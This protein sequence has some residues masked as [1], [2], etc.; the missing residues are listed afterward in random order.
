MGGVSF[1]GELADGY[2]ALLWSRLASRV[3]LV[4]ARVGARDSEELYASIGEIP[5]EEHVRAGG[6]IAVDANGVNEEL[7]NTQFIA[8]RV[9]D[10]IADRFMSRF[11]RRPSVD[12][13]EPDVRVNV[14]LRKDR[15]SVSVDLA[16]T[17]LHRRGYREPG[18]QVEAPMKE[19]LAAAMLAFADWPRIAE[20]GG[21]FVDPMC[22]SG[23]LVIEAA[24]MAG[25][26]APGLSRAAWG[27]ERWLG[28]DAGV[29]DGLLGE[30]R[31]RRDAGLAKLPVIEGY[32]LD[33]RAVDLARSCARR[34][35]LE[36]HVVVGRRALGAL[37]APETRSA[38]TGGVGANEGGDAG[39]AGAEAARG[40][41][42]TNP[43]YGERISAVGGLAALYAQFAE[44]LRA[45]FDGWHLA[46]ITPDS[47]LEAGLGMKA[48]RTAELYNG[49]I[50][51]R[52][53]VFVVGGEGSP[54]SAEGSALRSGSSLGALAAGTLSARTP[55][56]EAFENRLR[57]MVRH[58]EKWARRT[59]VSCYRVYDADLPDY[60]VAID[61]YSGARGDVGGRW[62]HV[63][64]YAAP[65]EIDPA[66]AERRIGDVLRAV[67]EVLGISG[68]DV[69]VKR[70]ERQRGSA[71]YER[72]SRSGVVKTT[73]EA[74][75]AFEVNLSDYLDTGIFLDHRM[76]RTWLREL[77]ERGG[78]DRG[79]VRFLNLF[80]YTA[81]ASV[82]AAA[83]G[84]VASTSVDLSAT[85]VE[86][87]RRNLALNGFGETA[88]RAV[89]EDVLEWVRAAAA[90][91]E[92]FD[93]VFCD[94]P[95][96]SNSKRMTSTWD[97]QRDHAELILDI[98]KLLAEDGTLVFS[99]NRR[100]FA[101]DREAL[102]AAGLVCEDVTAR[103]VPPDFDRRLPHVCWTVR[104][105]GQS[106]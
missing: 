63:A 85:Y 66:A 33:A 40:L 11:G 38:A 98:A 81:T 92:R 61:V 105:S 13:R 95:T 48:E 7:R 28:H 27:F 24:M 96:F 60:A 56:A 46:V 59:G 35:G 68:D 79:G 41:V 37:E 2:R 5:W 86:W 21:A 89:R 49:K 18:V 90:R 99:C 73:E 88:H 3:L 58:R 9:K 76:T 16:G 26:V 19:T 15:A 31:E 23:T 39:A 97:V 10:A 106:A 17:A 45:G 53:S 82:Y 83:G 29:W 67:P 102:E 55:A 1:S 52:V 78:R 25:D 84:A 64:E 104:R 101:L 22:G 20:G 65:S 51:S 70:R 77:A 87:A 44:R 30:A 12:V 100:G 34:A 93:L 94:P 75:L 42:A 14:G 32:D 4:L 6:T 80:A 47:G 71:Q 62:A 57:K 36:R 74:G 8:V 50:R 54:P 69:F 103:T 91:E 43:P 72:V